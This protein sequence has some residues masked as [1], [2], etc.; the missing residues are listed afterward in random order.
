M[1]YCSECG[2]S[3]I[4]TIPPGDTHL[5]Y[6]CTQCG[7]IHYSN[8][9][10]VVGT[11]PMWDDQILLCQR[12][13]QPGRGL[14]TVPAGF[15]E[16]GETVEEGAVRETLEEAN[17]RVEI[18]RLHTIYTCAG[19][20]HVYMLFLARLLDLNFSPGVESLDVDLFRPD[21]IP[22]DQIAFSSIRFALNSLLTDLETPTTQHGVHMGCMDEGEIRFMDDSRSSIIG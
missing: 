19:I 2:G 16:N 22:H 9:A 5:R 7:T 13:I 12:A 14:W 21:H 15:L 8:P 1:K 6:V 20:N 17:A 11:I 3:L 4:H 18:E 10:V